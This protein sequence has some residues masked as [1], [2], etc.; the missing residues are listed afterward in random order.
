MEIKVGDVLVVMPGPE[1]AENMPKAVS[2]RTIDLR[3]LTVMSQI[4]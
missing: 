2:G 4:V 1:R 3:S